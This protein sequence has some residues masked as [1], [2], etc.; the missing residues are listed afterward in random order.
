M[1]SDLF[2]LTG[3]T[4]LVTGSSRGLGRVIAAG[5]G[6]AG[7]SLV[8]NGRN[9]AALAEAVADLRGDGL[10]VRGV[11]F[12]VA[13]AEAI[14]R[15]VTD[16]EREGI[17]I[18]ILVNNAG[19]QRRGPLENL[20]DAQWAEVVETNLTGAFRVAR[21]VVRGMLERGRGKIINICS[22]MSE[23]ARPTTG[24]YAASKG[25]LKMLTRA[26]ATE[27]SGRGIQVNGLGPGY[28]LTEMTQ[29][30]ADDPAFDAWIR[31]R[32]PAGRWGRPA[33]LV[34]TAVFL[35]SPASDFVTG[36]VVYVDGGILAAL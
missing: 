9:E 16:L 31:G 7:A 28:I 3:R 36:Q 19:I 32:T 34:G 30:L 23:V 27:W 20:S 26:M 25:G 1:A 13:D 21:R 14:D 11:P 24:N 6:R 29:P 22:L 8:L 12:D 15:A 17:A 4:A 18:D 5:L 33:D 2:D 10:T 35:A